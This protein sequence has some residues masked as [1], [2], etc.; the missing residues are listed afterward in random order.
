[1]KNPLF[2]ILKYIQNYVIIKKIIYE[3]SAFYNEKIY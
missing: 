2:Y 3:K 1:M